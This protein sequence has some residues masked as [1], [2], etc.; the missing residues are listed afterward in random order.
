MARI[1]NAIETLTEGYRD[2]PSNLNQIDRSKS[3][4]DQALYNLASDIIK[5]EQLRT[6]IIKNIGAEPVE[7]TLIRS[8]ECISLLI[9]D[10]AFLNT[11]MDKIKKGL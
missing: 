5:S 11:A 1:E 8:I 7:S 6:E 10:M 9:G 4:Y 3:K 2:I